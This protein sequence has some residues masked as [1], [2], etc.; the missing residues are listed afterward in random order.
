MP[1]EDEGVIAEQEL[2]I[3]KVEALE[4]IAGELDNL[5]RVLQGFGRGGRNAITIQKVGG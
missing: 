3:R 5:N 2:E 1:I 4:S